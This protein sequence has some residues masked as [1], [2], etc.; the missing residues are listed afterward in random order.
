M[1]IMH[2]DISS[3]PMK[4]F[5]SQIVVTPAEG[6]GE[7][8]LISRNV[9]Y[10]DVNITTLSVLLPGGSDISIKVTLLACTFCTRA[11]SRYTDQ[12]I[13]NFYI[14]FF[15]TRSISQTRFQYITSFQIL[16]TGN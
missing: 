15:Q 6:G 3:S 16:K 4:L 12:Y 5:S 14:L 10:K 13:S 9:Q 11:N 7:F 8:I 2:M 1:F